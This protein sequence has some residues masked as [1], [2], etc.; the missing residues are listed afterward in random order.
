M[1]FVMMVVLLIITGIPIVSFSQTRDV[2]LSGVVKD[3]L[4]EPLIGATVSIKNTSLG[5]ITDIDGKYVINVTKGDVLVFQYIGFT[6]ESIIISNQK[7]LNVDLKEETNLLKEVTVTA[8]GLKRE[9]KALGYSIGEIKGS[10][11]EKA[12]ETNVINSLAGKVPGLVISQTASGPSGSSRV[13]IRGNTELTGNNQPLY[14]VDGVPMDNTNYGSADQNGGYDLGDGI[15]SIN[16]DDIENISVLKGPAASALYGSRA[17][18]GV[19]LITT[20]KAAKDKRI[21]IELNSTTTFDWQLTGYSNLQTTYGQGTGGRITGLENNDNHSYNKS[22]GP[23]IDPNLHVTYFD[24]VRRPYEYQE[25]RISGFFRTGYTT[26]NSVIINTF[27]EKSGLRLSYTNMANKDIVPNSGMNRNSFNLRANTVLAKKLDIDFKINYVREDVHNRPS[28]SNSISNIGKNLITLANTFNQSWLANSYKNDNGEYFDWNNHDI[29]NLN[30]YWIINEMMND[31]SKDKISGTGTFKYTFNDKFSLRLV[32][33]AELN[34]FNFMDYAPYSTPGKETGYMQKQ[35]FKNYTY[36]VEALFTYKDH[37]GKFDWGANVG[38]NIFHVDNSTNVIT[39]KNMEMRETVALQSFKEKEITEDVY[40]KQINSVFAMANI[41]YDNY[42]FL[43]ATI[44]CDKSSTLPTGSNTY[45]YPSV[46]GSF[47][48]S[49]LIKNK[50]NI[51]TFGKLRASFAQVGSDTDP[52]RLNLNYAMLDK[53]LGD[54]SLGYIYNSEIPNNLLKPTRTNSWEVG[55]DLSFLSN[56]IGLEFTYYS[57]ISRDQ[58]MKLNT[59]SASG[60]NSKIINAGEIENR[61]IE[62]VLRTRPV[63]YKD[64]SWDLSFNFSKNYNKVLSLSDGLDRF[65]LASAA[66]LDVTI[67]AVVGENYGS[68]MGYDFLRNE[69]GQIIIDGKTGLPKKTQEKVILGNSSWDWTGGINTSFSYKNLSLSA[70]F[71]VKVGGDIYS[72]TQRSLYS[73][74]LSK[75]TVE[76]RD[77]WYASEEARLA[78]GVT[79]NNWEPTGG[80]IAPGVIEVENPDGTKSYKENTIMVDPEKYWTE[81]TKNIASQ[82]VYDNSYVKCREI[83]LSYRLPSKWVKKWANDMSVS[84]VARNPFIIYKNIKDIDPD[85]NYNNTTGMGLECGSLPSRRSFGFNLNLKF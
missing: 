13:I 63:E 55:L 15:S 16:P 2:K 48:F 33:G 18:H 72:M 4:G 71:D 51:F 10:E 82:F 75:N 26:T 69:D 66:W 52:Y 61:G 57:Q 54:Y 31:S 62:M 20:K 23:R 3:H 38:A 50:N 67:D 5:T 80:F 40:R 11:L 28:L 6:S 49:E 24:G 45:L 76:G 8:L 84:F 83:T 85:S 27:S 56:R 81:V 68:I 78:A 21:G 22:W 53:S 73:T 1:T 74:G 59:S 37:L 44:R 64:F 30:P 65:T 46:S 43:D 42:L 60:Y 14:V 79:E 17:S 12:K 19:I 7:E 34:L 32:G 58:I 9:K 70:V 39:A 25:D 77:A 29:Y 36:N 47:L 41:A 35:N